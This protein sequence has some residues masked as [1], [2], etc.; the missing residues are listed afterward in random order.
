MNLIPGLE[1]IWNKI[2]KL[3]KSD[4]KV[5]Q[6]MAYGLLAFLGNVFLGAIVGSYKL[7]QYTGL[8]IFCFSSKGRCEEV[9]PVTIL[10]TVAGFLMLLPFVALVWGFLAFASS[11]IFEYTCIIY[12]YIRKLIFRLLDLKHLNS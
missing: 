8:S 4:S 5:N 11:Y 1:Y 7:S 10:L 12:N 3:L 6:I 9:W 2:L